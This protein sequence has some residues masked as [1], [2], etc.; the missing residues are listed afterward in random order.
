MISDDANVIPVGEELPLIPPPGHIGKNVGQNTAET[1][2]PYAGNRFILLNEF[3][4]SG[5]SGLSRLEALVWLVLFRDARG[6]IAETSARYIG[7][8]VGV[9]RR[10]VQRALAKLR[11]VGLL[12]VKRKGGLNRGAN[13]YQLRSHATQV[14]HGG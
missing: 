3:I 11:S 12:T 1:P 6:D 13:V 4:D 2:K 10:S 8:R 14:S 7:T 5:M 9:D